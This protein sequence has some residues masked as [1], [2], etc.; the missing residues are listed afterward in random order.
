M[1][2]LRR[3]RQSGMTATLA[4]AAIVAGATALAQTGARL[5]GVSNRQTG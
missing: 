2:M 5:S 3:L 1:P 4:F